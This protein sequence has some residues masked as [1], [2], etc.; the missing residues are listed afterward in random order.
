MRFT[1]ACDGIDCKDNNLL[2]DAFGYSSSM[3]YE[4]L[5]R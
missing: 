4:G 5:T 1:R 2:L 3:E